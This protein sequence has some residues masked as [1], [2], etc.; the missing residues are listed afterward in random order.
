MFKY[1]E[2]DLVPPAH[3]NYFIF[4]NKANIQPSFE[5]TGV[6]FYSDSKYLNDRDNITYWTANKVILVF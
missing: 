2:T 1:T 5:I 4:Q 6:K 3:L